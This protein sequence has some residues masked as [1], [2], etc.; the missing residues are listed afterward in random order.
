MSCLWC[1]RIP[2]AR[3]AGLGFTALGATSAAFAD[4][5]RV[6]TDRQGKQAAGRVARKAIGLYGQADASP[7]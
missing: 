5:V 2:P 4:A 1:S 3:T 7:T 6:L